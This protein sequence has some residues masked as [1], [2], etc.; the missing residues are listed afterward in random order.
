MIQAFGDLMN[1]RCERCELDNGL[2][3]GYLECRTIPELFDG[4]CG[5][6]KRVEKGKE[7]LHNVEL[8]E[9]RKANDDGDQQRKDNAN[10]DVSNRKWP[11]GFGPEPDNPETA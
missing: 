2:A 10:K 9:V 1:D 11:E 3:H 4:C 5:N 6:C 7:C 8:Q